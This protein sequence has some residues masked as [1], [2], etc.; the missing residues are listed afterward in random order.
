MSRN[1]GLLF[2]FLVFLAL[3]ADVLM[4]AIDRPRQEGKM[5]FQRGMFWNRAFFGR[6]G[7]VE[8]FRLRSTDRVGLRKRAL[9]NSGACLPESLPRHV[10]GEFSS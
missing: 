4:L 2:V 7:F 8:F 6:F 1:R 3:I 9:A 5:P 10:R